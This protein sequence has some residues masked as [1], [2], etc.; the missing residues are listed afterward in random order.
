MVGELQNAKTAILLFVTQLAW[1]WLIS[2]QPRNF[3]E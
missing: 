1:G 2:S 3:R